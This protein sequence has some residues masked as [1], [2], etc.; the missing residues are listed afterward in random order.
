MMDFL[1]LKTPA[2][3]GQVLVVPE[4]AAFVT[5]LRANNVSLGGADISLLDTTL[6]ACRRSTREAVVGS[7]DR[8]VVVTGHGPAFIHPGVWA[9][10]IV[11]MRLAAAVDGTALNLVVDNDAPRRA[12]LPVPTMSERRWVVR[13]IQ[14]A[15]HPAGCAY[16]QIARQT[17]E[18]IRNFEHAIRDTMGDRY[19]ESQMPT[20]FRA[21]SGAAQTGDWVDQAVTARRAVEADFGVTVEDRRVSEVCCG[22]LLLDMLASAE[23]F[24]AKYNNALKKYRRKYRVRGAQR[25][26]P[27][28]HVGRDR[29][30]AAVWAYRADEVRRRVFVS[31]SG[32]GLR[33]FAEDSEIGVVPPHYLNSCSNLQAAFA[34]LSGWRLRPRAL[35]LTIWAR[36]LLAD[37]FIHGIG[38]AKYDR[39]TDAILADY[40][41]LAPPEMACVSATL[42]LDLPRNTATAE[43]VRGLQHALRDLQYNPQR[44]LAAGSDLNPFIERRAEAVRQAERHRENDR[45]NHQARRRLFTDIRN[46]N[47]AMLA[48]RPDTLAAGRA[49]L[50][51][52]VQALQQNEITGGREYFFGLYDRPRLEE[53]LDALPAKRD[54]LV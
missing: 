22:P 13:S 46:I 44:R 28:L 32:D 54:F 16:E 26:I 53:L 49:E 27:D 10:H 2:D 35:T 29:C 52:A 12:V 11:A 24:A 15:R 41:G 4:P 40:Y 23:R 47:A 9:K 5:A 38:G 51:Q 20:F 48:E 45:Q 3:H 30:E 34:G 25:P 39:I 14:F 42:H 31:R 8:F 1:K 21:F 36:L 50:A 18:E 7:N 17:S 33:L 37:L 43:S 6:A 19:D